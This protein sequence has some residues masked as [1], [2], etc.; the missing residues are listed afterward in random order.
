V[1]RLGKDF[2]Q[3]PVGSGPFKFVS[4][5]KDDKIVLEAFKDYFRG[6]PYLDGV[7]FRIITE[8]STREAEFLAGNLDYIVLGDAQYAKYSKDPQWKEYL[9][10]VPELFTRHFGFNVTKGPLKD[11][12]VRQAINYAID[13]QAIVEKVLHGKAFPA[14]GV[15]PPSHPAYNPSLK[16]YE[17]NPE[18]ARQLLKDAGYASGF[19]LEVHA[20][21]HSAFGVPVVEAASVYLDQV[22]VKLKIVQED[23]GVMCDQAADGKAPVWSDSTGG[24]VDPVL[25]LYNQFH[26]SCIGKAGNYGAYRNPRVDE[27][28]DKALDASDPKQ[29]I[30]LVQQAEQI[31]V[32]DAP[33]FFANYNKAVILRHP[34]VNGLQPVPTDIDYQD[35]RQVWLSK[36]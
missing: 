19:T 12:R 27:L 4:W 36:K 31:I 21:E 3:K 24:T 17:Y 20:S 34:W 28:L 9:L 7:E 6:R 16:G 2:G 25:Y 13:K 10:E 35:L 22:G 14:T 29:V 33:W 1:E 32:E 18:K 26:S 5:S 30:S 23:Y 11:V 8:Q 15:F